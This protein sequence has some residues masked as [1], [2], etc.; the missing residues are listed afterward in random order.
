MGLGV[1]VDKEF[2][3]LV[4]LCMFIGKAPLSG[5]TEIKN[6]NNDKYQ[7][8]FSSGKPGEIIRPSSEDNSPRS[9]LIGLCT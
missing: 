6:C 5:V 7:T 8:M 1:A 2:Q 4:G 9:C 3:H